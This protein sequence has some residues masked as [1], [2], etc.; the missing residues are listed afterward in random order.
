MPDKTNGSLEKI[1]VASLPKLTDKQFAFVL[2]I[3]EGKSQAD[4]YRA[5]YGCK[6]WLENSIWC[7]AS[8]LSNN[9]KV[10]QWK[11][12]LNQAQFDRATCTRENHLRKLADLRDGAVKKEQFGPAVSAEK[13]R[14]EVAGH[15]IKR[16]ETSTLDITRL[17]EL[18]QGKSRG[19][20]TLNAEYQ[21]VK[22]E[23]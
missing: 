10:V 22:N 3:M 19:V 5:A 13:A 20:P 7:E 21:V 11:A 23:P 14:G 17:Y 2:A 1:D 9:P 4:A 6:G 12:A 8:K 15:Y 16:V 18:V